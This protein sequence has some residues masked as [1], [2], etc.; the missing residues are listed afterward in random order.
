[1]TISPSFVLKDGEPILAIGS[2]GSL[3]IP[4]AIAMVINNVLLFDMNIQQAINAPR[5]M[6]IDRKGPTMTIEQP[7]FDPETVKALEAYGYEMKDVGEYNMA[8]GG[9]A[10]IYLDKETGKFFAGADPRRNYQALAY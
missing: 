9:I 7:R 4:P 8:V 10:A 1:S 6:A 3:A 2:P 5:A